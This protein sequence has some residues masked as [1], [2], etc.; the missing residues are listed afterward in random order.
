MADCN[1]ITRIVVC[2]STTNPNIGK[3]QVCLH[4]L[5]LCSGFVFC[6]FSMSPAKMAEMIEMPFGG[7]SWVSTRNLVLDEVEIPHGKGQF[8]G[9]SSPFKRLGVSAMMYAAKWIV[10]SSI[11]VQHAM[12]PF[13]KILRKM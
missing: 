8:W 4:Q 10:Q 2:L 1:E 5:G 9:L 13:I 12:Q 6:Y 7:L 3:I 11:A